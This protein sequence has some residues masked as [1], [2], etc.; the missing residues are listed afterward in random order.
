M[1][2]LGR[3]ALFEHTSNVSCVFWHLLLFTGIS[4]VSTHLRTLMKTQGADTQTHA[5]TRKIWF[6]FSVAKFSLCSKTAHNIT[7][8]S[9][10]DRRRLDR[11]G[12]NA[13]L[14]LAL[15][16]SWRN[17][18]ACHWICKFEGKR[19]CQRSAQVSRSLMA[20]KNVIRYISSHK[21]SP[22]QIA[23]G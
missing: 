15:I 2:K 19:S 20:R 3:Q 14:F 5:H 23:H 7:S 12:C 10:K 11:Q 4:E 13:F 22:E 6:Y 9:S 16:L 21:Y 1:L 8:C 17:R 18:N